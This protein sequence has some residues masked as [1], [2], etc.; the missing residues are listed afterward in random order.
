MPHS[1]ASGDF[2]AFTHSVANA[3]DTINHVTYFGWNVGKTHNAEVNGKPAI[4]MG[5]E[6]NFFDLGGD[7]NHGPEWYIEQA[8]PD[9]S[10][11][12]FR[13]FYARGSIEPG[14]NQWTI[15]FDIGTDGE[16]HFD[17]FGGKLRPVLFTVNHSQAVFQVPLSVSK[18]LHV[19]GTVYAHGAFVVERPSGQASMLL[20]TR[21]GGGPVL[22][23]GISGVPR[24]TLYAEGPSAFKILDQANRA[25]VTFVRGNASAIASTRFA[26][27]VQ[28]EGSLAVAGNAGFFGKAPI[29]KPVGVA[30]NVEAIHDALTSL[31][32]IAP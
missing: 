32:L 22:Q 25:Q 24:W 6:S 5:F 30:M 12:L 26:S 10:H 21:S 3:D 1:G 2:R 15:H 8:A 14:H 16:G 18:S 4:A 28:V 29:P 19:S 7:D 9:G 23:F 17:V 13:P 20:N 27:G 11:A 31:G